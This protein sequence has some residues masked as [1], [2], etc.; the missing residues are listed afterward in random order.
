MLYNIVLVSAVQ[1][2]ESAICIRVSP[3]PLASLPLHLHPSFQVTAKHRVE[4][5]AL[6]SN[7]LLV[8]YLTY[9][10]VYMTVLLSV[11]LTLPFPH[12]MSTSPF[13]TCASLPSLQ[14]GSS[15][16]VF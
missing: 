1:Q 2:S 10:D 5:P 9:G 8:I 16:S 6:Y 14:I 12:P 15:V 3:P 7:F 11:F 13:A 4:P